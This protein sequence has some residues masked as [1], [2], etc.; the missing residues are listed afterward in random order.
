MFCPSLLIAPATQYLSLFPSGWIS[1]HE[2]P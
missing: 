1:V 2:D